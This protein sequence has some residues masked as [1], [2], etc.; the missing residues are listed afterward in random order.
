MRVLLP[1][2]KRAIKISKKKQAIIMVK[3]ESFP[4][5]RKTSS[6]IELS[7]KSTF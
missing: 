2:R 4:L 6:G 5:L 7:K 1:E 3:W